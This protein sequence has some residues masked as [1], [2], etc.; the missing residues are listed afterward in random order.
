MKKILFFL[1]PFIVFSCWNPKP[2]SNIPYI[3]FDNY[4]LIKDPITRYDDVVR[5]T[6]YFQD[7]DGDIG[8]DDTIDTLPHFLQGGEYHYNF[9]VD[10]YEKQNGIFVKPE[11]AMPDWINKRIPRL[12]N[13]LPESIEGTVSLN[14]DFNK[15]STTDYDT[16]YYQFYIFDRALNKSNVI[17]TPEIVVRK[18]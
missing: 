2:F 3:E 12:S 1:M 13:K 4:E 6:F 11:M 10:Y 5:L 17:R 7:G 15:F 14:L 18:R 8:L 16:I 9:I